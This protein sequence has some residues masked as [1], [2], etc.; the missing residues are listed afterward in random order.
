MAAMSTDLALFS[1]EN[2]VLKTEKLLTTVCGFAPFLSTDKIGYA[3]A[4]EKNA[5]LPRY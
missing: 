4:N 3:K 5:D 1:N 2:E